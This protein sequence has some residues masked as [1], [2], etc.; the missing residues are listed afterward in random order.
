MRPMTEKYRDHVRAFVATLSR[1][2]YATVVGP[3]ATQLQ[4]W[5]EGRRPEGPLLDTSYVTFSPAAGRRG[6]PPPVVDVA[7]ALMEPAAGVVQLHVG[8]PNRRNAALLV[9]QRAKF[10]YD[11]A[12]DLS[13]DHQVPWGD[14][15]A[16]AERSWDRLAGQAPAPAAQADE[17]VG[18]D[19]DLPAMV[20]GADD[21]EDAPL[22]LEES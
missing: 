11:M 14:A 4:Q 1:E 20:A 16:L 6:N 15:L 19:D 18:V 2:P 10:V 5:V 9:S 8:N 21:P 7:P 12:A 17:L 22:A 13:G 3:G